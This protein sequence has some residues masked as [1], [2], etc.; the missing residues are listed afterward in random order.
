MNARM[1]QVLAQIRSF[2]RF[3]LERA[4]TARRN[5]EVLAARAPLSLRFYRPLT[6][7]SKQKQTNVQRRDFGQLHHLAAIRVMLLPSPGPGADAVPATLCHSL[8]SCGPFR[9]R[10]RPASLSAGRAVGGGARAPRPR[11]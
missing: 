5:D 9:A 3:F 6:R 2:S 8:R 1:S 4:V 7:S 10:P 11:T